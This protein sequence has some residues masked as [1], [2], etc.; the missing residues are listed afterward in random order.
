MSAVE[1]ILEHGLANGEA[2]IV[3]ALRELHERLAK[4]EGPVPV[5]ATKAT[6]ARAT[7]ADES[8]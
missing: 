2:D 7:A 8:P 5:K 4:C 1:R 3:A 6:A